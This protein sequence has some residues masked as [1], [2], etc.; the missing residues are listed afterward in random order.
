MTEGTT[1]V[2]M[3]HTQ[4]WR[5]DPKWEVAPACEVNRYPEEA[6]NYVLNVEYILGIGSFLR[7]HEFT[8]EML[9][10]YVVRPLRQLF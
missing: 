8:E 9:R 2:T 10:S 5:G 7:V 1:K 3:L 4:A 6:V